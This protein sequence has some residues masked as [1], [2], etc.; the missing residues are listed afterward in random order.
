MSEK[1]AAFVSA[2]LL[3][4][5][6]SDAESSDRAVGTES[7][8]SADGS[9]CL[10]LLG[11]MALPDDLQTASDVRWSGEK[12]VLITAYATGVYRIELGGTTKAPELRIPAGA[13]RETMWLPI[14]LG[15]STD[16]IAMG[17]PLYWV[18]WASPDK[19]SLTGQQA[20]EFVVDLDVAADRLLVLGTRR[21]DA[22][23]VGSDGAVA[24][25]GSLKKSLEDLRP[26]FYSSDG[27]GVESMDACGPM[28]TGAVRW[29][30]DG[31]FVIVP[32]VEPGVYLYDGTGR[33]VHTW[34]SNEIGFDTECG[35][36]WPRC[37]GTRRARRGV[38]NGS[39][40]GGSSMTS[41]RCPRGPD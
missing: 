32:G 27:P 41:C 18:G 23:Q 13:R 5:S 1:V 28:E 11:E 3:A 20:F 10:E 33:L 34:Q 12:Q 38:R 7:V 21:D 39:T 26:V 15:E 2:L 24:W 6:P 17:G 37:T 9:A 16:F 4:V 30:P 8:A 35:L 36:T 31:S 14:H 22:G 29:L 19:R 25:I 40:S